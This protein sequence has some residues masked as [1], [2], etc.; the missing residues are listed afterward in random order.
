MELRVFPGLTVRDAGYWRHAAL[1]DQ[2]RALRARRL[3]LFVD[4][5]NVLEGAKELSGAG[6]SDIDP[7][8]CDCIALYPLAI[9]EA[10]QGF[11]RFRLVRSYWYDAEVTKESQLHEVQ[12]ALHSTL[13]EMPYCELILGAHSREGK[14]KREKGVDISLAVSMLD[15]AFR[16][17]HDC[18]AIVSGDADFVPLVRAV[19]ATGKH[20]LCCAFTWQLGKDDELRY[21]ADEFAPLEAAL[22]ETVPKLR[23]EQLRQQLEAGGDD[24]AS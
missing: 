11:P 9:E 8:Q 15:H 6:H 7:H 5:M 3:M 20:V 13:R 21:A 2:L 4:A 22:A 10:L 12:A 16:D 23:G 14:Q 24:E 1:V 18:A 19:K 17:N